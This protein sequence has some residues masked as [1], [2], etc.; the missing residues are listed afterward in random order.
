MCDVLVEELDK[1]DEFSTH[2]LYTRL[3]PICSVNIYPM[4]SGNDTKLIMRLGMGNQQLVLKLYKYTIKEIL[5]YLL[6]LSEFGA[7]IPETV[8]LDGSL[9]KV[10]ALEVLCFGKINLLDTNYALVVQEYC[11]HPNYVTYMT[12]HKQAMNPIHQ[13]RKLINQNGF[14]IDYMPKNFH[15]TS[16]ENI[17]TF[18][19][20]D[21]IFL[22]DPELRNLADQIEEELTSNLVHH[23]LFDF[24][25]RSPST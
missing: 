12:E 13:L 19:Y 18:E 11:P 1:G 3:Q 15:V 20:I 25:V 7:R 21:Y 2:T 8:E 6:S 4:K 24:L 14:I 16:R 22:N 23:Q 5:V 9:C 10:R 17:L